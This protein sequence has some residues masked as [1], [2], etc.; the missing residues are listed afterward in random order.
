MDLLSTTRLRNIGPPHERLPTTSCRT[1][2][3][4]RP[5]PC[6]RAVNRVPWPATPRLHLRSI[7]PLE[8][9]CFP[10]MLLFQANRIPQMVTRGLIPTPPR[11]PAHNQ[12]CS[13]PKRTGRHHQFPKLLVSSQWALLRKPDRRCSVD[14]RLSCRRSRRLRSLHGS[15]TMAT[16][17]PRFRL[18]PRL[19]VVRDFTLPDRD[20]PSHTV[21]FVSPVNSRR[22]SRGQQR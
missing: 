14:P 10:L 16:P 5:Q 19:S 4:H 15:K 3:Q 12:I 7:H 2:P 18:M 13:K 22:L 1:G 21:V 20:R 9:L 6:L 17:R 11:Q 8:V